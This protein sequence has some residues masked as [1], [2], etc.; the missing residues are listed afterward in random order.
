MSF[1]EVRYHFCWVQ[2]LRISNH[3]KLVV[4][5]Q[6]LNE[7]GLAKP[8]TNYVESETQV[9]KES[10]GKGKATPAKCTLHSEIKKSVS[11]CTVHS[12]KC[13]VH[14]GMIKSGSLR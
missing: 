2:S 14:S 1:S 10:A 3:H 12:T 11:Q 6:V 5:L 4:N 13:T 9:S 8:V 7:E